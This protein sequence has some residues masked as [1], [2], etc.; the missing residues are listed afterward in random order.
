MNFPVPLVCQ[1]RTICTSPSR[2]HLLNPAL[3]GWLFCDPPI[4]FYSPRRKFWTNRPFSGQPCNKKGVKIQRRSKLTTLQSVLP[5]NPHF[6]LDKG[7]SFFRSF[8]H[9]LAALEDLGWNMKRLKILCP[10][11]L[12]SV[13]KSNYFKRKPWTLASEELNINPGDLFNPFVYKTLKYPGFA[14]LCR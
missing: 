1:S 12:N 5:A 11:L 6:S 13:L 2:P 7:A 9:Y 14:C 8:S 3:S 4:S 10:L